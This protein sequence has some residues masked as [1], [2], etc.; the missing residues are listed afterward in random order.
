M[1]LFFIFLFF[2]TS[3]LFLRCLVVLKAVQLKVRQSKLSLAV[4]SSV[5]F[6]THLML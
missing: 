3:P 5:L 4:I 2:A 1:S 6:S